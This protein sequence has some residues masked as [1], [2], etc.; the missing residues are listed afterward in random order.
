MGASSSSEVGISVD[1]QGNACI[2]GAIGSSDLPTTP[3]PL[4]TAPH[5][6]P[7]RGPCCASFVVRL[8]PIGSKVL[9]ASYFGDNKSFTSVNAQA[10]DGAGNLYIAGATNAPNFPVTTGAFQTTTGPF[11]PPSD[12]TMPSAGFV[13]KFDLHGKL[14][15]STYFRDSGNSATS[16]QS[17]AADAQGNAYFSGSQFNGSLPTTAGA[18]QTTATAPTAAFA[19]KL[20]STGSKLV[21]STYLAGTTPTNGTAIAIDG[22]GNAYVTGTITGESPQ[23]A[24]SFPRYLVRD[25]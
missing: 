19:A 21:Y 15:Y 24:V 9:Y 17:I 14:I 5:F 11:E 16:I 7:N 20:D 10:I 25:L 18:F 8:N 3:D 23:T 22:G 6:G 2:T 1:D 13:S 4:Q 12:N